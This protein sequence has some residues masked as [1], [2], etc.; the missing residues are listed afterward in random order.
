MSGLFDQI[1]HL[2]DQGL[3]SNVISL[4]SAVV[5]W[6]LSVCLRLSFSDVFPF[7]PVSSKFWLCYNL[8]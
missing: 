5:L 4:V 3:Y 7:F 1:Q 8:K 6:I 2:Y